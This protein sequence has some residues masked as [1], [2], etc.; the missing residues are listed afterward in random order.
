[1]AATEML[2]NQKQSIEDF[3]PLTKN[4]FLNNNQYQEEF[5]DTFLPVQYHFS[6]SMESPGV[7]FVT[8]I[9]GNRKIYF[10]NQFQVPRELLLHSNFLEF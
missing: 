9:R 2:V 3:W 1:M 6:C 8:G 5:V 4:S 10:A 7:C